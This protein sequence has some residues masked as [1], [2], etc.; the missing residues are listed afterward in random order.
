MTFL[1][2]SSIAIATT[3]DFA[4]PDAAAVVIINVHIYGKAYANISWYKIAIL[5]T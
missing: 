1:H 5:Q 3:D 4:A 2:N